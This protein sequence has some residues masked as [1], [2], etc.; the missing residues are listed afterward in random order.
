MNSTQ[1]LDIYKTPLEGIQLVEAS[2]GTG[3]TWTIA[4][5]YV[6]L[7]LETNASINNLLVV[8]FT[9]AATAELR[10]RLRKRLVD[11]L[12]AFESGGS[13]DEF[14]QKMLE[15][16]HDADAARKKLIDCIRRFDEAA[17]YTIHGFCQ[18]V[19]S[20]IQLP[21][22]LVEPE[23]V[24][25]EREW[26]PGLLQREWIRH[27]DSDFA[28]EIMQG[29]NITVDVIEKDINI[30]LVKPFLNIKKNAAISL[31]ELKKEK[32]SILKIW[33]SERFSIIQDIE[34]ADGLSRAADTYKDTDFLLD[35]LEQ[36]LYGKYFST[37]NIR[38]LTPTA[39]QVKVKKSGK[40]PSHK[41][42]GKLEAWFTEA[43]NYANDMRYS[44]IYKVE[45]ALQSRK[46]AQGLIS[47]QDLLA[48]LAGAV[49]DEA[50][51]RKIRETYHVAL[52]D[53]FQDTDPLQF[54]IFNTLY[55]NGGQPL[56][57]VGDPKQ[58]IYNFRGAD[59]YTYLKAR[60]STDRRYTLATNRRSI[61]PLV[62]AVNQIFKRPSN[63]FLT[64]R[65][66]F[67]EVEADQSEN[68]FSSKEAPFHCWLLTSDTSGKKEKCL[69]KAEA[70]ARSVSVAAKEISQLLNAPAAEKLMIG[71][72]PLKPRDIAV[73]V[74]SHKDGKA[75]VDALSAR[76]ISSV[77]RSQDS[78]F[79]SDEAKEML[80]LLE[81]VANPS[82]EALVKA[83]LLA[84]LLNRSLE[85]LMDSQESDSLWS[86]CIDLFSSLR[87]AWVK[88]GFMTMWEN[89]VAKFEIYHHALVTHE[90][91]RRLTNL[92]HL[93]TLMQTQSDKDRIIER[94]LMWF[95]DQVREGESRDDTQLRL[96]SDAERV[97]VL[98]IHVSKGLEYPIVFCPFLWNGKVERKED[99]VRAE[100]QEGSGT[101][102]D[103][104]TSKFSN[105]L[106]RMRT[107]R[108]AEGLR[109]LYVA[110]T[111]AKYRCYGV[112]GFVKESDT[113]PFSWLL[114]AGS[115]K[116][117]TEG[118]P[119]AE[120][121]KESLSQ[122]VFDDYRDALK[123]LV[124]GSPS[125]FSYS[126]LE[127]VSAKEDFVKSE[128]VETDSAIHIPN[129]SRSLSQLWQVGSFTGLTKN[130]HERPKTI[131]VP[132]YD[133]HINEQS[134]VEKNE[135]LEGFH[136]LPRG[137]KA[138]VFWHALFEEVLKDPTK[139]RQ[140]I[141]KEQM[142]K[143]DQ[144]ESWKDQIEAF[145]SQ[146]LS[147]SFDKNGACL[148]QLTSF[149]AEMEFLYPV[150]D[151]T[152]EDFLSLPDVPDQYRQAIN[153]LSFKTLSGFLK[154]FIDLVYFY[155]GQYY[156]LD[157]KTN[158]LGQDNTAYTEESLRIAMADS[159]YYLQYWL[160]VLAVHRY[161]KSIK[162]D[163]D[164]DSDIGGVR[165]LFLRGLGADTKG[166]Y[167]NKPS[168]ALIEALD[169][170]MNG[171][172]SQRGNKELAV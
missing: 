45:E 83:A 95:R 85:V 125:S 20:D 37:K 171:S 152:K 8:T 26:L 41:I 46:R 120:T 81:A 15:A 159:H 39:F 142:A 61:E 139:S 109:V 135:K 166:V 153:G 137:A 44:I 131:E 103:I 1:I 90:G 74:P 128:I 111:R 49:K 9:K 141:I 19:L 94:Q 64:D 100:Y 34:N 66:G 42:W 24:P 89:L 52:I 32:E 149:K 38:R 116:K 168:R 48:L 119:D 33:E 113:A 151:L 25:D 148:S 71:D 156:V 11:V 129:F 138:G 4:G 91:E 107:E 75:V 88:Y 147:V 54:E 3:K 10:D 27:C 73:L 29:G 98:T 43:D 57:L 140:D 162:P 101:C 136:A 157:Y 145:F 68:L 93:S 121:I 82:K 99:A 96:E 115:D 126:I 51:S 164:Y 22:F 102:L 161:L 127:E 69:T 167:C 76:G 63:P 80:S 60:E 5:L 114:F 47:Y 23:I 86:E 55:V 160:Y 78:V 14:C 110:L 50:I 65:L 53:E 77:I 31:D 118:D 62:K 112:W 132:D 21:S 72:K 169:N 155:Q 108:I 12:N 87:E 130:A 35:K 18:R 97:Q 16:H 144:E 170:I 163:Y 124:E 30:K 40:L 84:P 67:V 6:R 117:V 59:I 122:K 92:R 7:I 154:G 106:N 123:K 158:F 165:Y 28:A 150:K 2:A 146:W 58:A 143:Y 36:W 105:S 17:I 13:E 134:I 133:D 104:G 70:T 172:V 79:S 56:F